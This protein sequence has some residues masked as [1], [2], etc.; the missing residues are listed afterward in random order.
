[1]EAAI[2]QE[3]RI[4]PDTLSLARAA[5]EMLREEIAGVLAVRDRVAVALSGGATPRLLFRLLGAEYR[6]RIRWGSVHLFWADER[7]V[8]PDHE[9]SNFRTVSEEFIS[10][11]TMPPGNVHRIPGELA[12]ERAA[13]AYEADLQRY[14]GGA[15]LPEFDLIFLG[16]GE[17]GHTASLF[18]AAAA[19]AEKERL[20][21]AV[22][23]PAT[24][25][26]RVTLTLPVLNN[27]SRAAFLVSG[28]S[29]VQIVRA[30][31][32]EGRGDR[33]PA[34]LVKPRR[35]TVV[36]LLDREA[37]AGLAGA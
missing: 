25:N 30:I 27:A 11:I 13:A 36:W 20:A 19:L 16:V 35:G 24:A 33:Y 21:V 29:K 2:E 34:G 31:L 7:A 3:I 23:H 37:A 9:Q 4:L 18:P 12:P 1:M 8:P 28:R 5:A 26:W 17:D 32:A 10:K 6:D 15:R 14:F 22:Y